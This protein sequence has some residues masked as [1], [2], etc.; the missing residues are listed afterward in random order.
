MKYKCIQ[1]FIA[2]DKEPQPG[3]MVELTPEQAATLYEINV[4]EPYETKVLPKPRKRVVKKRKV[5]KSK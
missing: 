2:F 3:D 5:K 1:P 4:I